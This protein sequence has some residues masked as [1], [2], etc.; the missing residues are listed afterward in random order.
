MERTK[1]HERSNIHLRPPTDSDSSTSDPGEQPQPPNPRQQLLMQLLAT[2]SY[3][4]ACCNRP[5]IIRP[6]EVNPKCSYCGTPAFQSKNAGPQQ[7]AA[8]TSRQPSQGIGQ[9]ASDHYPS[10]TRASVPPTL[11]S[12][13]QRMTLHC[14][15]KREGVFP[16]SEHPERPNRVRAI[17]HHLRAIGALARCER[18]PAR[19]ATDAE[20]LTT[21]TRDH[22]GDFISLVKNCCNRPHRRGAQQQ[23]QQQRQRQHQQQPETTEVSLR[24][25]LLG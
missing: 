3:C 12:Y 18:V 21:H 14:E 1:S 11:W 10:R 17:Y 8:I 16:P 7:L 23:P 20:I 4:C 24:Y 22:H 25:T 13:D 15:T 19:E 5:V 6:G 9:I 2:H